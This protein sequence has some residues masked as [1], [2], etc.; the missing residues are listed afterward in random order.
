MMFLRI[1]I[2]VA[3]RKFKQQL[4]VYINVPAECTLLARMQ[5]YMCLY[6]VIHLIVQYNLYTVQ[7]YSVVFCV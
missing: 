6:S 2:R 3:A 4:K 1:Y 5:V 7:M